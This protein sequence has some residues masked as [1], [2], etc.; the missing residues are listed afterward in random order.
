M[1][2]SKEEDMT[3]EAGV[4]VKNGIK[5]AR[6]RYTITYLNEVERE[7][8]DKEDNVYPDYINFFNQITKTEYFDS[9]SNK[10]AEYDQWYILHKLLFSASEN[11]VQ[12]QT[13]SWKLSYWMGF[14]QRIKIHQV[15][16]CK[17][18]W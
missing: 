11:Y 1:K 3:H 16:Q 7:L 2:S 18:H 9:S 14:A 17:K 10:I 4:C 8:F 5:F 12:M 6:S 15:C 13:C